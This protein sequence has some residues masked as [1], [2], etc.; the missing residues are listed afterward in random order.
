[1]LQPLP[2]DRIIPELLRMLEHSPGVVLQ[3][4][5]GSGKT[6][7]I[8]LALLQSPL[9]SSGTILMLEPRRLAAVNAAS[10]LAKSV[11]ERVGRSVGYSIRFDRVVSSSTRLEV[12]TEGI[13]TR[14]LQSDAA[15]DGVAVVIFDEFHERSLHADTALAFCI[16]IQKSI[17]PELKIIVMSATL[18]CEPVSRLL[19]GV[20]V[21]TCEGRTYPVE[22]RYLGDPDGDIARSA[23]DAVLRALRETDGDILVFLPGAGEI[24]RCSTFLAASA[25]KDVLLCQLYGDLPFDEQER[26]ITPAGKRKVVLSTNIAETSLTIEGVTVVIDSGL[27]RTVRFDPSTGLNRMQTVKVSAASATQRAGRSGRI[28]PGIC[29][30]LW[31]AAAGLTLLPFNQPEIKVV[32]LAPL[33]L[34]LANWGVTDAST[35]A[36]LDTPSPGALGEARVLLRML[37][38]LDSSG[39]ITAAGRKMASLPVHPRLA[40]MVLEGEQDGC[41]AAACDLAALLSEKEIFRREHRSARSVTS[42]DYSDRLEALDEWRSGSGFSGMLDIPACRRVDR[43]A[44]SLKKH[45]QFDRPSHAWSPEQLS[46]LLMKGFPDR[47]GMQREPA[48][49]R[50]LLANGTGSKL[51]PSAAVRN[52]QFIVAVEVVGNPGCEGVIHGAS[53][54]TPDQIRQLFR[55]TITVER[56]T[57]WDSRIGKVVTT[58]TECFG[59]LRLS[60]RNAIPEND[61]VVN[62]LLEGLREYP[63]LEILP[64]NTAA[65]QFQSRVNFLSKVCHDRSFPDIS[66]PSLIRTL[67]QWLGPALT[68]IRSMTDLKRIDVN[69]LLHACFTWEQVRLIDEGAPIHM[70]VPSGSR[71]TVNY[72]GGDPFLSVKLQEMFGLAETP[73]IGWGRVPLILHLLSPA[74]RPIQVT[75]DLRSFWESTYPQV[76]KEL[77][78]RYPRHPWPDDPWTAVPTRKTARAVKSQ[79]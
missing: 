25:A 5:P 1:M 17:R 13:L 78:G 67:S 57:V 66:T 60:V 15:L 46:A 55:D 12:L 73:R 43:V 21:I 51:G 37:G 44:A 53:A 10:W 74:G 75:A 34:E 26:A 14:R 42:C 33:A 58:V 50:Y 16:E 56:K 36:W 18:D 69:G 54:V 31:S 20:P 4:P 22:L 39:M 65:R 71:L 72:E 3:A 63:E 28:G 77:K 48:S 64:W 8:P 47:I 9:T 32:D 40:A 70:S 59:A 2:V 45:V 23:S 35:M 30:R 38:G 11:D 79:K 27:A 76:K 6:S 61:E 68:G 29:Y 7:R 49:D 52:R 62:A 19:G 41:A 24:R